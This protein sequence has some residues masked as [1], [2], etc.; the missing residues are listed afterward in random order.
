M[1]FT[2]AAAAVTA[3]GVSQ[4]R[5]EPD[6]CVYGN[7][8]L[9]QPQSDEDGGGSQSV[10]VDRLEMIIS[11]PRDGNKVNVLLARQC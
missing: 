4:K 5:K 2:D 11:S 10:L 7:P 6:M 3:T 8:F 9:A 1:H